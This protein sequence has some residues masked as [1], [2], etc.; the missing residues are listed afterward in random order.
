MLLKEGKYIRIFGIILFFLLTVA[1]PGRAAGEELGSGVEVVVP[2][3]GFTE[4]NLKTGVCLYRGSGGEP[5]AVRLEN[6]PLRLTAF[7]VTYDQGKQFL[8]AEERA[9]LEA[10]NLVATGPAMILTPEE[11]RLPKGGELTGV[12]PEAGRLVV[13]GVFVYHFPEATFRGTGGFLLEG[14]GWWLEGEELAGNVEEGEFTAGGRLK[15]RYRDCTG[16]A[17]TVVYQREEARLILKGSPLIRWDGGVL[18]GGTDTVISYDLASG[19]AKVEGATK[20]R[21]YQE[22]GVFPSGD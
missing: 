1:V 6:P 11:V 2:A 19:Q 3:K 18:Q 13:T 14:A 17:E 12:P 20:T 15:F 4:L 5:V 21:F 8:T 22:Q 10:E 9:R 7:Q 16:E